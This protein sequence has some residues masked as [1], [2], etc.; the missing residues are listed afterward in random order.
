VDEDVKEGEEE[1]F[2]T[3]EESKTPTVSQEVAQNAAHKVAK[4]GTTKKL[5]S[6]RL[7]IVQKIRNAKPDTKAADC[8]QYIE[9]QQT[10]YYSL[11]YTAEQVYE[12]MER[13]L[14]LEVENILLEIMPS[15]QDDEDQTPRKRSRTNTNKDQD[16]E[17]AGDEGEEEDL[18][19]VSNG[20]AGR[21]NDSLDREAQNGADPPATEI[22]QQRLTNFWNKTPPTSQETNNEHNGEA[23]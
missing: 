12:E 13:L 16:A 15:T 21:T 23:Q 2:D 5:N 6:I 7:Q 9:D 22:V 20:E 3:P 10:K 14:D 1:E 4:K 18:D 17:M 19:L 11:K 8:N